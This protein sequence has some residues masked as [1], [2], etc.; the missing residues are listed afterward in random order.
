MGQNFLQ[1]HGGIVADH[2]DHAVRR[3]LGGDPEINRRAVFLGAVV[4]AL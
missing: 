2:F 4:V 3:N 1:D